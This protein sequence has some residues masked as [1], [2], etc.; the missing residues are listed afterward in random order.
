MLMIFQRQYPVS[1]VTSHQDSSTLPSSTLYSAI[2]V[3]VVAIP[4]SIILDTGAVL[5]ALLA[6]ATSFAVFASLHVL[7]KENNDVASPARLEDVFYSISW[8]T[9]ICLSM[10]MVFQLNLYGMPS[11]EAVPIVQNTIVKAVTWIC[12]FQIVSNPSKTTSKDTRT[13]MTGSFNIVVY[14][15]YD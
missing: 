12:L 6:L 15:F 11:I 14:C 4:S 7:T 8:R 3:A 2:G 9:V 10:A 5:Y 1:K 13:H